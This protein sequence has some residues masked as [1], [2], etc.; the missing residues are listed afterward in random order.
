MAV[1]STVACAEEHDAQSE[2][3]NL[4][5]ASA[6]VTL[7]CAWDDRHDLV[8]DILG[9]QRVWPH[10]GSG[11]LYPTSATVE[12]WPS[13]YSSSGQECTYLDALVTV[14]YGTEV[15]DLI[16]ESLEPTTEFMKLDYRR[17]RWGAVNGDPLLKNEAPG[18]LYKGLNL[19]RTIYDV[20]SPLPTTLLTL[21]GAVNDAD[22]VSSLLGL[23]FPE[24]TLLFTPPKMDRSITT[25]GAEGWT[26]QLKF[27]YKAAGWNKFWREKTEDWE[28]MYLINGGGAA[29]KNYPL[30]DFSD[31]L[32]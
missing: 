21:P 10:D 14:S 16:S 32:Y 23:T 9:N 3:W 31:F 11:L 6:R 15:E 18:K 19:I 27:V 25:A 28:D 13:I 30:E 1:Y 24:E 7:R 8:Q 20:A 12:P 5:S 22:Y 26:L 2:N 29:Y 4:D 17:F